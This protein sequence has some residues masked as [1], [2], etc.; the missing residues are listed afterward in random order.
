[1]EQPNRNSVRAA[2]DYETCMRVWKRVSPELTPYEAEETL[3]GAQADPCCMGSAAAESGDVLRGFLAEERYT[4]QLY[5]AYARCV[6]NAAARSV[7]M[8]MARAS[9]EHARRLTAALYLITG[10]PPPLEARSAGAE[11]R[12][13]RGES[14]CSALRRLYHAAVC[15]GF[16]YARAG[17]ETSDSCLAELLR[18]L[19][20][21]EY[22][23][24]RRLLDLL[25]SALR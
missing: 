3:P 1:M 20:Q 17:G 4:A 23:E 10:N 6:P 7:L 22:R 15:S 11:R 9:H 5:R 21:E 19:S 12:P 13:M 18:E 24:A 25:A 2:Y 8:G 16:N 14:Y